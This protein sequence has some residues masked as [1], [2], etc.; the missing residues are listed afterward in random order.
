MSSLMASAQDGTGTA[1]DSLPRYWQV[2]AL[3]LTAGTVLYISAYLALWLKIMGKLGALGA[4][5]ALTRR[6][7]R[8]WYKSHRNLAVLGG[9]MIAVGLTWAFLM[10]QWAYGG[11]H[12]RLAHSLMGLAA[13]IV[14][15][16]PIT[17]GLVTRALRKGKMK[18]RMWHIVVGFLGIAMMIIG[19]T[20][21]W[22]LE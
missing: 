1:E 13:G 12:L 8:L 3:L 22:A 20:S 15:S 6:V 10:V 21:G 7:G 9:S 4:K 17:T 5:T 18:I 16:L 11:P 19:L 14:A 2:H